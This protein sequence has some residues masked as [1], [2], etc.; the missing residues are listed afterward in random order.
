MKQWMAYYKVHLLVGLGVLLVIGCFAGGLI[1]LAHQ[2][3]ADNRACVAKGGR[4][5]ES[6]IDSG[7]ACVDDNWRLIK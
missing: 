1:L 6:G 4:I 2:A 5:V 3:D 7:K